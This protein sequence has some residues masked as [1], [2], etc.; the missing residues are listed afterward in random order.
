MIPHLADALSLGVSSSASAKLALLS[1]ILLA[2][3][4]V[5]FTYVILLPA[6]G[7]NMNYI[8]WRGDKHLSTAIPLLTACIIF[9][10]LALLVT[11]SPIGAPAPPALGIRQ[12]LEQAAASTGLES[13]QAKIKSIPSSYLPSSSSA[14]STSKTWDN[15]ASYLALNKGHSSVL[16]DYFAR[17]SNR[18]EA[19]AARNIKTIGWTG[20]VLGS[21]G[22]YFAVFG[23]VGLIGLLA[24]DNTK[25]EDKKKQ[26]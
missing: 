11:L 20:A 5:I 15:I 10:W 24:P 7:H 21:G 16:G 18:A 8:D 14:S 23:A 1:V 6:R 25:R 2:G 19:W 12:R 3:T 13:L 4:V 17:V 22:L 26:F 9:G